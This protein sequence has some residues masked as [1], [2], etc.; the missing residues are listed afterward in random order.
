MKKNLD[1]LIPT[2]FN[3]LFFFTPL[4]LFPKTS[5]LFEFNKI[6]FIYLITT[7]ILATWLTRMVITKKI[8]FRRTILDIPLLIFLI[9]QFLSYLASIDKHTSLLGYYGRFNG[10]LV[11]SLTYSLLYWAYVSNMKPKSTRKS[12]YF[13]FTSAFLVSIYGVVQHFGVD[14][15]LWVQDVQNRVFSTLGQ[16]NWLATFVVALIPLS[17]AFSLKTKRVAWWGLSIILFIVLLY[18]KSRSGLL[19]LLVADIILW[20]NYFL[21][22][23]NTNN[24]RKKIL[25]VFALWHLV[26]GV[27]IFLISTPWTPNLENIVLNRDSDRNIDSSVGPGGTESGEIRKIVWKGAIEV[28]GHYPVFGSGVE[29]FAYSFYEFRPKEHNLVSEW[30]FL[31][32]KAHNEYLNTAATT[33]TIGLTAYLILISA[34]LYQISKN[35]KNQNFQNSK[36][37]QNQ[38]LKLFVS[39]FTLLGDSDLLSLGVF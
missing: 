21:S 4:I 8:I 20:F 13:L 33:G 17:Y 18:T 27:V 9:S 10:G 31:Y 16:P 2:L 32:N 25:K 19:G 36:Q 28:W 14:K 22:R 15:N 5:E 30:D 38:N 35:S 29:T 23:R 12:L 3:I 11:S 39:K 37:I 1:K 34:S 26:L 24:I 7:L 6:V